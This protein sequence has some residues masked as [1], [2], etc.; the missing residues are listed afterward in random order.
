MSQKTKIYIYDMLIMH[1]KNTHLNFIQFMDFDS[2]NKCKWAWP[3]TLF[4]RVTLILHR[5]LQYQIKLP[6]EVRQNNFD[7]KRGYVRPYDTHHI[8]LIKP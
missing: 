2:K 1:H 8:I 4:Q 5:A 7:L 3:K 6:H